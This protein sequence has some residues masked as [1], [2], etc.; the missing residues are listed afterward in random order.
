MQEHEKAVKWRER[1]G[2]TKRELAKLSGYSYE[3]INTYEKG[4]TPSR[5][6]STKPGFNAP[7]RKADGTIWLRYRNVCAGVERALEGK[8]FKW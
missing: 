8:A 4:V 7:S 6:W 1:M 5:T 2:L 3:T